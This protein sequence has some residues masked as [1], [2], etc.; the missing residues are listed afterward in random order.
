M[1]SPPAHIYLDYAAS[2]PVDRRVVEAM[3]PY[4]GER[5]GNPSSVHGF[6]QEAEAALDQARR[7]VAA[8]LSCLPEEIVF[9]SGGTESDNLAIRGAALAARAARGATTVLTTPVEHPAVLNAVR[10]LAEH[11]GFRLEW[12]PV[13]GEGRVD[14]QDVSRRLNAKTAVVSVIFGNNEIGT[15]NPVAAIAEACRAQGVVFHTDAV[16]AAAHLPIR[17][18][19]LKAD[20]VSMGAHKFYGPKGVGVLYCRSGVDLRPIQ[21]GGEQERGR[22]AGTENVPLIVG[23]ATAL[24]ISGAEGTSHTARL[25]E[26]RDRII[27]TVPSSVPGSRLTGARRDRLPN[28][29]SFVLGGI[30]A[31]RLLA[32]L[33]LAGF[34]C[35]S[36]SACKTGD[37]SPS[38]VLLALGLEPDLALGS[39]RVTVG[40]PTARE[41][42]DL[43]LDAL[44]DIVARQR[45]TAVPAA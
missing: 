6:G 29:A 41:D 16:Q 45:R 18:G 38:S 33:D 15:V 32:A 19:E 42:V 43:F 34:A 12:I 28:H 30:D 11:H 8:E 5:F 23:L 44:P 24:R 20:L 10:H 7:A 13:D 1:A 21:P 9:T 2:S 3:L 40:R 17:V 26:L 31:N 37:P 36:G 27:E 25:V 35:S 39:L 22:R 14:P 4:F